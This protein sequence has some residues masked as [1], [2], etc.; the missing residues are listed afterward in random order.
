MNQLES[1]KNL[2]NSVEHDHVIEN[3]N[4]LQ[5]EK[6]TISTMWVTEQSLIF[7]VFVVC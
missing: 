7:S 4:N 1:Q 5:H 6:S 3:T 2:S